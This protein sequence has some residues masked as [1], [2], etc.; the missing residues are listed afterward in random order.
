MFRIEKTGEKEPLLVKILIHSTIRKCYPRIYAPE[1]VRFFL[2]YHSIAAIERRMNAGIV[3][4]LKEEGQIRGTG[5][6]TGEEMGGV[7]VDPRHQGKGYG[8]A[9]IEYLIGVALANE[10]KRIWLDATPIAKPLYERLGFQVV[11]PMTQM[12]GIVPLHYFKMEKFL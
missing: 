11:S 10:V 9:I 8:T 3:I 7:Y 12:V 5:F 6:L 2:D 4:V 1:V